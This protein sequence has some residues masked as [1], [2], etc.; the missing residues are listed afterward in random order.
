MIRIVTAALVLLVGAVPASAQP[1][2]PEVRLLGL[3]VDAFQSLKADGRLERI[4]LPKE[5]LAR[6]PG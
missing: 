5:T 2:S 1:A 6:I 3:A 4:A